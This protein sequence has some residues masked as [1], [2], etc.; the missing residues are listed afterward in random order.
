[1]E[2]AY[3]RKLVIAGFIKSLTLSFTGL[4]DCAFVGHFLGADGLSAMKLAVPVFALLSLFS[5][6]LSTGLSVA[7]SGELSE[8]GV[9]R[10][11]KVFKSAVSAVCVIGA[12]LMTVGFAAPNTL[13]ELFTGSSCDPAVKTQTTDYLRPILIAALPILLYDVFGTVIMIEGGTKILKLSSA[14]LFIADVAGDLLAVHLN[15]GLL[16]IAAASAA[17]FTAA[18]AVILGFFIRGESMFRPGFSMPEREGLGKVILF[19]LPVGV[20]F[21]CDILRPFSVN[22][23]I[24][25]CGTIPGLAALTIQDSVRFVPEALCLG[26]SGATL[27]LTGIFAAESDRSALR[28]EKM[29]IL[30]WSLIGGTLTASVLMLFASPLIRIFTGDSTVCSLGVSAL[31]LYLPGVPF[32]AVNTSVTAMFQGLGDKRRSIVCALFHRLFAPVLCAWFLGKQFGDR[33]IYA[34]FAVS[35]ILLTL[36]MT[37]ALL[38][39]KKRNRPIVPSSCLNTDAAADLKI[40]IRNTDDAVSAS[41]RI[42]SLC[43]EMGICPRQ[44]YFFALTAEELATNTLSHGFDPRKDNHLELR[45]VVTD[46]QLILRVRDDGRPF[47][48]KERYRMINPEDPTS[49]IGLRIIFSSADEVSYHSSLNLN[50]VC[51]RIRRETYISPTN[52]SFQPSVGK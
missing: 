8:H 29:S 25:S 51:V 37:A 30:L 33:G 52:F 9:Q 20:R 10:A 31:R 18:F 15:K 48:L 1:M 45:V 41:Q 7:V 34:S 5:S 19:G 42:N 38:I 40:C 11:N 21:L 22:R 14:V 13:A 36:S 46:E 47:D 49:N 3:F 43:L 32:I 28:Q 16:G 26:I 4:I 6:V 12:L 50:N 27:I 2:K 23:F 35:E 39:R 24:L 44:A 17:A